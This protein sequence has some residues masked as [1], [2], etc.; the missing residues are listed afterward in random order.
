MIVAIFPLFI[1]A[2]GGFLLL[3]RGVIAPF[4][5]VAFR[6][7]EQSA[8]IQHLRLL[9]WE[10]LP[11]VDE[12]AE[13]QNHVAPP[14]Y[15]ALRERIEVEFVRL[16][17]ALRGDPVTLGL[18]ARARE[19]WTVADRHAT[20]LISVIAPTSQA[21]TAAT[22]QRF[23]GA[24]AAANDRLTAVYDQVSRKISDDHDAAVRAYERSVWI[25]GIAGAISFLSIIVGVLFVGRI[26]SASVDRLVKG[27]ALFADGDRQHRIEI[28]LPSELHRVAEE[29]NDMIG[30]IHESEEALSRL[31]HHDTLTG[32][33]NRRSFDEAFR[34]VQD[35]EKRHGEQAALL[36]IDIDHFKRINDQFGHG[37]GD[38][39]LRAISGIMRRNVRPA[40]KVFRIGGEEF[41][42]LLPA[43][44]SNQA[45]EV[46]DRL[47]EAIFSTPVPADEGT[48]NVSVS[49]GVATTAQA[50]EQ[51][52]LMKLADLALY[53]A[54]RAGRN[55][56]VMAGES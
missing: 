49:I 23:H 4:D 39:V 3:N 37:V 52:E 2:A 47:R 40:D 12:F 46:A 33:G 21:E 10:T 9:V 31:A 16:E 13:M 19:D 35:R 56:V 17:D 25:A 15:R 38:E 28:A 55:R 1:S 36:A 26:L 51:D 54:K 30:R 32:L 53:E 27:A 34:E 29:F 50:R 8:P 18:L 5:D 24:A 44:G 6:Q 7:R 41:V 14:T 11:P 45:R 48:I 42:A 43:A 20:D 22:L